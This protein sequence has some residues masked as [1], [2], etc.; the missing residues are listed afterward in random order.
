MR[1]CAGS[2]ASW[3]D[4]LRGSGWLRRGVLGPL[5][6]LWPKADWLPRPLRLKTALTN[7]SLDAA[8]AYANTVSLCRPPLL[9]GN[10][11]RQDSIV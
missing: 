11:I 4:R 7:L 3:R 9:R 5:A 6:R 10:M 2:S 1:R 8:S